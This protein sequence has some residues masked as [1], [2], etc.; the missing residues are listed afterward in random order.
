MKTKWNEDQVRT[1]AKWKSYYVLTM[2]RLCLDYYKTI[3]RLFEQIF[4]PNVVMNF[5]WS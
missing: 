5:M 2:F 3:I 1:N 4:K